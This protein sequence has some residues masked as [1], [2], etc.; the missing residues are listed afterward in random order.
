M[1]KEKAIRGMSYRR[2]TDGE[3]RLLLQAIAEYEDSP[4]D[5]A[6]VAEYVSTRT[7]YQCKERYELVEKRSAGVT[8]YWSQEE[9]I[10]LLKLY[11][12]YGNKWCEY[13][14]HFP[15]RSKSTIK[16]K[17][18]NIHRSH[19]S[20]DITQKR[21][22]ALAPIS[23]VMRNN[24]ARKRASTVKLQTGDQYGSGMS[25]L[26][27]TRSY[28]ESPDNSFN[29]QGSNVVRLMY[30]VLTKDPLDYAAQS[31]YPDENEA[32]YSCS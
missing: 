14:R 16:S 25:T 13:E 10:L 19:V 9:E 4:I 27:S 2:W 31:C 29:A 23:T 24:A 5:W 6:R 12:T 21:N 3:V 22:E 20:R 7:K 30:Y 28:D 32:S 15:G 26:T 8:R 11:E 1:H 17:Y 18:H